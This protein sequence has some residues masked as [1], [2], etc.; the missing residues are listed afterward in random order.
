MEICNFP[1]SER[2]TN[3]DWRVSFDVGTA[4]CFVLQQGEAKLATT[5]AVKLVE[6]TARIVRS[7]KKSIE[8][9]EA[10][11]LVIHQSVTAK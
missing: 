11:H 5:V 7:R 4:E 6:S 9:T 10:Y 8:D 1:D 3:R 2:P